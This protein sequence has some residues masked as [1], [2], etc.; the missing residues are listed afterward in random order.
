MSLVREGRLG[1]NQE[2]REE[3]ETGRLEAME[4]SLRLLREANKISLEKLSQRMLR[5]P[6]C[7]VRIMCAP[8]ETIRQAP[9]TEEEA[10]RNSEALRAPQETIRQAPCTEEEALCTSQ[11]TAV[12]TLRAEE[13]ALCALQRGHVIRNGGNSCLLYTSPS[14]RDS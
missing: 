4:E 9:C 3:K 10:L 7:A 1:S 12:E 11:G 14:P 6:G 13:S 8:Q 5:I 2:M